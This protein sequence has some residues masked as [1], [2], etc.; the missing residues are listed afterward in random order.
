MSD[1]QDQHSRENYSL[2][3]HILPVSATM[4]GVCMTVITVVQIIPKNTISSWVDGLLAVDNLLFLASAAFSYY[5][6]R[7]PGLVD[8]FERR[9]DAMFMLALLLMVFAGFMVAFDLFVE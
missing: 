7:H 1:H 6:I 3:G 2:A 4:V 9:A 8:R 5:S